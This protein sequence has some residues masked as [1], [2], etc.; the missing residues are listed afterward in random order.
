MEKYFNVKGICVPTDYYMVDITARLK[1]MKVLVDKRD[2]FVINRG[3]QYGK[4]TTLA[5]LERYLVNEYT[6]ILLSFQ[7][8][9]DEAFTTEAKFCQAFL[10]T[11]KKKLRF[12]GALKAEQEKW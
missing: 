8:F 12:S 1:K 9:G 3:R 6:P 10:R 11:I 5:T 7:G 2:Y 4:T